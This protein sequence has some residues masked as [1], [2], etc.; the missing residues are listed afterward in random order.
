ME[1]FNIKNEEV[2]FQKIKNYFLDNIP[3]QISL[4]ACTPYND[5][6]EYHDTSKVESSFEGCKLKYRISTKFKSSIKNK[7]KRKEVYI[8]FDISSI[9]KELVSYINNNDNWIRNYH[10]R[11]ELCDINLEDYTLNP[12]PKKRDQQIDKIQEKLKDIYR[13]K[14]ITNITFFE[15]NYTGKNSAPEWHTDYGCYCNFEDSLNLGMTL[16]NPSNVESTTTYIVVPLLKISKDFL[17]NSKILNEINLIKDKISVLDNI[18]IT[19]Y[20]IFRKGEYVAIAHDISTLFNNLMDKLTVEFL[21]KYNDQINPEL[22][23]TTPINLVHNVANAFYH[24]SPDPKLLK[25]KNFSRC[26]IVY[27]VNYF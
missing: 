1:Q 10:D 25:A 12:D 2:M 6:G 18:K 27:T 22:I 4:K 26:H 7:M 9:K 16:T 23:K 15:E 17:S 5:T 21:I 3:D 24:K 20:S 8:S 11:L 13:N 19:F 14:N